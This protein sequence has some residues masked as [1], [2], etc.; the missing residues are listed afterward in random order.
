MRK[1]R[2]LVWSLGKLPISSRY[3]LSDRAQKGLGFA[4]ALANDVEDLRRG[5]ARPRASV[6]EI[7]TAQRVSERT[8]WRWIDRAFRECFAEIRYCGACGRPLPR[9]STKRRKYCPPSPGRKSSSCKV[10]GYRREHVTKTC[11]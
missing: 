7:A 10:A 4:R 8:V 9:E 5:I 6:A 2:D 3:E 11:R 1:R